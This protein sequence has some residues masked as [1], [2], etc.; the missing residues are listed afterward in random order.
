MPM[1]QLSEITVDDRFQIR[2]RQSTD[3]IARYTESIEAGA[4]MPPLVVWIEGGIPYLIDGF[5]RMRAYESAGV[6]QVQVEVFVGDRLGAVQ[7]AIE[8]NL[9]HGLGMTPRDMRR[10]AKIHMTETVSQGQPINQSEYA[11]RFGVS[12][13]TVARW[14]EQIDSAMPTVEPPAEASPIDDM[15]DLDA[16]DDH[17]GDDDTPDTSENPL[18]DDAPEDDM[19]TV[20]PDRQLGKSARLVAEVS[21]AQI[22]FKQAINA[23]SKAYNAI[24]ALSKDPYGVA[25]GSE[26]KRVDDAYRTIREIVSA[27]MPRCVCRTCNGEKCSKCS[28]RGWITVDEER[29]IK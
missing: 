18:P 19:A 15:P 12:R 1:M 13:T 3:M 11:A 4:K 5:H 23:L 6:R 27:A 21:D 10:A 22:N 14:L 9:A 24:T 20:V 25:I 16:V 17:G 29:N 2:E 8:A 28:H 7:R 26:I